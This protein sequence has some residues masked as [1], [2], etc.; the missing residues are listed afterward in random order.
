MRQRTIRCSLGLVG[1]RSID[2]TTP[3]RDAELNVE[4]DDAGSNLLGAVANSIVEAAYTEYDNYLLV[5]FHR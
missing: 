1:S 3:Q 5:Y 4:G 2:P